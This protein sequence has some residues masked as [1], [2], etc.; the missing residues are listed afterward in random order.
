MQENRRKRKEKRGMEESLRWWRS[1]DR[2]Y[3]EEMH[4]VYNMLDC[5][6]HLKPAELLRAFSLVASDDFSELGLPYEVMLEAGYYFV[7]TRA[8]ARVL[9]DPRN[10]ELVTLRTWPYKVKGF[11]VFRGYEMLDGEGKVIVSGEEGFMILEKDSGRPVRID[12]WPMLDWYVVDHEVFCP[13]CKRIKPSGVLCKLATV[14]A[15][16]GDLD[17]NGHVNNSRYPAFVYDSLPPALQNR[18]WTD[19]LVGFDAETVVGENLDL[20]FCDDDE[21]PDTQV[22]VVGKKEDGATGFAC[23]FT[24]E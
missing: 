13:E 5:N 17:V 24:F 11:Q 19:M 23:S 14:Q 6:G 8:S 18:R 10:N 1:D 12:G 4:I 7:I 3:Q 2:I 21:L 9:R 20:Y 15:T 22:K 16:F